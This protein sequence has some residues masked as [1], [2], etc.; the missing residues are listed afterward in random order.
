MFVSRSLD[1]MT[2]SQARRSEKRRD[3][4]VGSASDTTEPVGHDCHMV[5]DGRDF[6]IMFL[7]GRSG[8]E[9]TMESL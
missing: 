9:T 4:Q 8:R 1:I 2:G 3:L 7:R 6:M 5:E